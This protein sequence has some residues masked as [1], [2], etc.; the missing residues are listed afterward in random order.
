MN[1]ISPI[2]SLRFIRRYTTEARSGCASILATAHS[3]CG[4][5]WPGKLFDRGAR[6]GGGFGSSFGTVKLD[7]S[8]EVSKSAFHE[9]HRKMKKG[10]S[11]CSNSQRQRFSYHG[12][13]SRQVYFH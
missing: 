5:S 4:D 8:G 6:L 10:N 11:N 1:E 12:L 2:S 7:A 9:Q 3:S 13:H